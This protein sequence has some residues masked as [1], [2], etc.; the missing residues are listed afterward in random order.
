LPIH[1]RYCS[2]VFTEHIF[3]AC[4]SKI[5][6][7]NKHISCVFIWDIGLLEIQQAYLLYITLTDTDLMSISFMY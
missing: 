5:L 6:G 1:F 4:I 7:F 3:Y 2:C